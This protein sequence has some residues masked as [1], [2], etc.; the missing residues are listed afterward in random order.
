MQLGTIGAICALDL[1]ATR[2][3]TIISC[4]SWLVNAYIEIIG[5]TY[6]CQPMP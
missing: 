4:P 2:R 1:L 3:V 6:P 5:Q